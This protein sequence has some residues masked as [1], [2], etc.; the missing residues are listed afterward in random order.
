MS[1]PSA[2]NGA[3][4]A[5]HQD[6]H[7]K[8]AAHHAATYGH[9]DVLAMLVD[10]GVPVSDSDAAGQTVLHACVGSIACLTEALRAPDVPDAVN[11]VDSSGYS[12][13]HYAVSNREYEAVNALV[14]VDGVDVNARD[15]D[16]RTPLHWSCAIGDVDIVTVLL[17]AGATPEAEDKEGVTPL[18]YAMR[19]DFV[20]CVNALVDDNATLA[21]HR[22]G[23]GR[24][25]LM[26][27]AGMGANG[28]VDALLALNSAQDFVNAVGEDGRNALHHAAA[29]QNVDG[30]VKVLNLILPCFNCI[31][32]FALSCLILIRS[33]CF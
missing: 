28:S 29:A 3:D 12:A 15:I 19:E 25:P 23:D 21:E 2:E 31:H 11:R 7:G 16:E 27:S 4:A 8:T 24:T 17:S 1:C 10:A 5:R 20:E 26:H 32:I 13:L 6:E 22:D 30:A 18:E 9:A 33:R 14:G